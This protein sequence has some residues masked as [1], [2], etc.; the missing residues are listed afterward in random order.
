MCHDPIQYGAVL[1]DPPWTFKTYSE[2]GITPKGAGGQYS[3]MS[4]E[5]IWDIPLR[6]YMAPDSYAVVWA[7]FPMIN[8]AMRAIEKWGLDYVTGGAWAK[9]SKT[10]EKWAF[11]TGYVLR[12]A[13][14]PFLI[15]RKGHP[16][17]RSHSVR[18][19]IAAPVREH[20]RKPDDMYDLVEQIAEGPYLELFARQI[21]GRPGWTHRG[22][23][24]DKFAPDG[25]SHG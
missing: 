21:T 20:S 16:R 6:T 18:N 17:T 10:G 3:T 8:Q 15:A 19:L 9:Q 25:V 1:V 11:G 7:T 22:N 5:E 13:A 12:S 14:E 2:K 4:T 24:L 23:E